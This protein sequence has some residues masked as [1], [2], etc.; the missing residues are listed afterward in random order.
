MFLTMLDGDAA[1][2]K[3]AVAQFWIKHNFIHI[4]FNKIITYRIKN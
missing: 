1:T 4:W 3:A 2:E